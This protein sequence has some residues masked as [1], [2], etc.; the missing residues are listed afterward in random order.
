MKK[1]DIKDLMKIRGGF[2]S[3][4][5]EECKTASSIKIECATK[6]V[7]GRTK[8]LKS[9]QSDTIIIINNVPTQKIEACSSNSCKTKKYKNSCKSGAIKL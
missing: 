3:P 6:A 8:S 1:I 7:K 2:S 5:T 4:S 9:S